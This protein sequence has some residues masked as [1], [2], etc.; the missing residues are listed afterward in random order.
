[1]EKL[2]TQSVRKET[3]QIEMMT[4]KTVGKIDVSEDKIKDLSG[5]LRFKS[6]V[7]KVEREMLL[8]LPNPNCE[9][10][11]KQHQHLQ[12]IT[13][14]DMDKKTELA[15][16]LIFGASDYTKIKVQELSRVGQLGEPMVEL[17]RFEW[18][19]MSPRKESEIN[20]LMCTKISLQI[21]CFG[22]N[23]YCT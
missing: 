13:M 1:M 14:T 12:K 4:H 15:V 20:K 2:N 8:A 10:V 23:R 6:E 19:L 11:L 5:S 3:E 9:A 18:V 22:Y 21:R 16:H 7:S 17:T